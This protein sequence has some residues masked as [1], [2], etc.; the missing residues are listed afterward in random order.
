[1]GRGPWIPPQKQQKIQE[2][3]QSEPVRREE[4]RLG[5]EQKL[6]VEEREA[7][8][9]ELREKKSIIENKDDGEFT[10]VSVGRD[11]VAIESMRRDVRRKERI[12]QRDA[13]LVATGREKDRIAHEIREIEEKVKPYMPSQNEMWRKFG[14][15]DMDS[16]VR[17][18]MYFQKTFGPDLERL[19][20]LKRMIEP[21]DPQSGNLEFIRPK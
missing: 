11:P 10:G 20:N 21:N 7:M 3:P 16:A 9:R 5:S 14:T 8:E 1:M 2:R 4:K 17:K 13:S 18:N 15:Q 6:S 19:K 12:L